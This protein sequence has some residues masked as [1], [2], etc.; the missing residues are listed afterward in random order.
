M[1]PTASTAR[2][3]RRYM[4]NVQIAAMCAYF[5]FLSANPWTFATA[6]NTHLA[7][8]VVV[9]HQVTI[10]TFAEV[11][12]DGPDPTPAKSAPAKLMVTTAASAPI[13]L[14]QYEPDRRPWDCHPLHRRVLPSGSD[15]SELS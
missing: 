15:D 2:R 1:L 4:L 11:D 6:F 14:A 3:N 10:H 13:L 5:V 8:P 9:V 12:A 7:R